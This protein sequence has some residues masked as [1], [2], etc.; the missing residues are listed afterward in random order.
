MGLKLGE[1]GQ[2]YSILMFARRLDLLVTIGQSHSPHA[3]PISK[4][5]YLI[6]MMDLCIVHD[7]NTKRSWI[8]WAFQELIEYQKVKMVFESQ[9]YVNQ[10]HHIMFEPLHKE[11]LGHRSLQNH[12]IVTMLHLLYSGFRQMVA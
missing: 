2:K 12:P 8:S 5:K 9:E 1:Y 3:K 4:L 6:A 11:F 7:Q 10:M